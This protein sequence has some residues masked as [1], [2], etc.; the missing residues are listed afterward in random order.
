LSHLLLERL[1]AAIEFEAFTAR[2]EAASFSNE[3]SLAT[4][5]TP[6]RFFSHDNPLNEMAS[7]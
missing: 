2:L 4:S 5:E 7:K 6:K 1:K 3:L